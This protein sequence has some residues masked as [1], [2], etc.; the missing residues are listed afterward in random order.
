MIVNFKFKHGDYVK[1]CITGFKGYII[2][3]HNFITGCNHYTVSPEMKK[4]GTILEPTSFD[5]PRLEIIG[6]SKE[7]PNKKEVIES[8]KDPGGPIPSR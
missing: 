1:D 8:K 2:S 4:D 7:L 5:E 6:E 3:A